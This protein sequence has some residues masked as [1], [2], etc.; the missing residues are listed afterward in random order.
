MKKVMILMMALGFIF[1]TLTLEAKTTKKGSSRKTSST[2]PVTKGE[3]KQY[4]DYLTTQSFYI[5]KGKENE[6]KLEYPVSGNP[7]LVNAM[8][9]RI[10]ESLNSEFTGE[11]DSPEA[12]MRS[13]LKGKRDVSYGQDGESLNEDIHVVYSTPEIITLGD[14]GYSYM[15]GAHGS[16]W[17][18]PTTFLVEDGTEF[19]QDMFPD[20]SKFRPYILK[21]LAKSFD[22]PQSELGEW[23]FSPED[24]DYPGT[25]TIDSDGIY[26]IYQQ[27]EIGPYSL[28]IPEAV[29]PA[30]P[31][32][33]N[34]L[35]PQGRRFF[36]S[37]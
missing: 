5:K 6:I 7:R 32:V 22:I 17:N 24:V 3:T 37:R 30:T 9:N 4:G 12:L 21:G 35:T 33:I 20:I 29:V 31:D 19:N 1:G 28:G 16:S 13:A 10:K 23:I 18:V 14:T 15:G 8:R 36:Q 11:L 26:F 34:L 27:Y 25:I 2:L